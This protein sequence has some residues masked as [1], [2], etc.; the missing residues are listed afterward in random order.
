MERSRVL[1]AVF[2]ALVLVPSAWAQEELYGASRGEYLFS[3]SANYRYAKADD[4]ASDADE[5]EIFTGRG[6][7]SVFLE[8]EHEFGFE[9]APSFART[10]IGGDST[11]VF[12][13]AFYN[14]NLWTSPKTTFYGGPQLGLLYVEPSGVSSD[15][16]FSYGIH[17]GLRYWIDPRISFDIEPRLSFTSLDSSLGGDQTLFD[18]FFG[19]SIKF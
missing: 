7:F 6:A 15:T 13:G 14:Y 12:V 1:F 11:D 8:R 18:I 3:L 2:A 4:I 10:E 17:A 16:A 5:T 19:I 9:L